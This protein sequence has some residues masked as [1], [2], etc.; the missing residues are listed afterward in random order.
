MNKKI[1]AYWNLYVEKMKI[2]HPFRIRM[3]IVSV[4]RLYEQDLLKI[5]RCSTHCF[6]RPDIKR[7]FEQMFFL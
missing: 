7:G 4:Q 5:F 3:L 1:D 2:L 6:F